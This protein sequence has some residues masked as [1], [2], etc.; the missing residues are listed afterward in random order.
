MRVRLLTA[1][2]VT[3]LAWPVPA[4]AQ[5]IFESVGSRALGMAGAFVAVADDST[6]VYWNPA[7]LATAGPLGMTIEWVRFRSGDPGAPPEAGP[8]ARSARF[9]SLGTWPIGFSYARLETVALVPDSGSGDT[10]AT[11]LRTSQWG[12]TLLQTVVPGLVVGSTLKY[13]R[14]TIASEPVTGATAH[15]ALDA[16]M[17]RDGRTTGRFDL[18]L[19]VMADLSRVRVGVTSRNLRQPSFPGLAD[20]SVQLQ[21]QTR[22]GVAAFPADGLTLAMDVDLDTVDLRGGLRRVIAAGGEERLGSRVMVRG[23]ARWNLEGRSA[24]DAGHRRQRV[25]PAERVAG[26]ALH[27]QP[28]RGRARIRRRLARRILKPGR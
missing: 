5:Q 10:V 26:R 23:G 1:I 19:G 17:G 14:G 9:M 15:D 2:V 7:G 24:C 25:G 4:R 12:A 22:L 21:R 20:S 8:D 16:A 3:A 18:D 11:T 6:A 13:V 27:A 28:D